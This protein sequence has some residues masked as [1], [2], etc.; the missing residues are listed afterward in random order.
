VGIEADQIQ[1]VCAN[2][3]DDLGF[4]R[5]MRLVKVVTLG[6][7]TR[8]VLE[9][10]SKGGDRSW[11]EIK[12]CK[13]PE[14]KITAAEPAP[15]PCCTTE[16]CETPCCPMTSSTR[17]WMNVLDLSAGLLRQTLAVKDKPCD[18]LLIQGCPVPA[19]YVPVLS[20]QP[21]PV[22]PAPPMPAPVA[23]APPPAPTPPPPPVA[24]DIGFPV[25]PAPTPIV[26]PAPPVA[27][28]Y[29]PPTVVEASPSPTMLERVDMDLSAIEE[30]GKPVLSLDAGKMRLRCKEITLHCPG[31]GKVTLC[32]VDHTVCIRGK[33]LEAMADR[34]SVDGSTFTLTGK[35][36]LQT[37]VAPS[38]GKKSTLKTTSDSLRIRVTAKE[39]GDIEVQQMSGRQAAG[40]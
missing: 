19:A 8:V 35:V 16:A 4:R 24:Q 17:F 21:I 32:A 18:P 14:A 15:R 36:Q 27:P 10:G 25:M 38:S 6:E 9:R 29:G 33:T 5:C 23:I 34:V 12:V 20:K 11:L 2:P 1:S 31:H 7:P 22:P 26:P 13:E 30:N 3:A 28:V 39:N 40:E 37:E